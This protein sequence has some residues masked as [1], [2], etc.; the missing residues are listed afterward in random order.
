MSKHIR[1]YGPC[2]STALLLYLS[3]PGFLPLLLFDQERAILRPVTD[4]W[5][6]PALNTSSS[7]NNVAFFLYPAVTHFDVL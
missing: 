2:L 1:V 3:L 4:S 6:S 5:S 7:L